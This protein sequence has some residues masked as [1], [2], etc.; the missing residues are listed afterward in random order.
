[1]GLSIFEEV[2]LSVISST[3][4]MGT[5]NQPS[6]VIEK[7]EAPAINQGDEPLNNE[8]R[9][10]KWSIASSEYTQKQK[11]GVC[12]TYAFS[13]IAI[14]MCYKVRTRPLPHVH[15]MK[16]MVRTQLNVKTKKG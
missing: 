6:E 1:M 7:A 5:N 12:M 11:M 16:I 4:K 9:K 8:P 2:V 15:M 10:E 3:G 14:S 13:S